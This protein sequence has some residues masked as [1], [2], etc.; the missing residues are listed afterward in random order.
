MRYPVLLCAAAAWLA[1]ADAPADASFKTHTE[2]AYVNTSGNTDASAFAAT[3]KGAKTFENFALRVDAFG[4]YAE[5]NNVE[6]KNQWG[7]ELNY[8]RTLTEHLAFNYLVGYKDDRFSG[9]DYQFYTGPGLLHHT[10]A[11]EAHTLNTQ[12][13]ILYARDR[14]ETGDVNEYA[15]LK[16][17]LDY[18]W[19]IQ[20]NLKL[21]EEAS[22]RTDLSDMK[23]YFLT[24]KTALQNKINSTF[25]MGVSYKVDYTNEPVDGKTTTDKTLMVSLIIDY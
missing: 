17:G 6:S 2:L 18:E 11:T 20:E 21:I 12:V 15:A 24:S 4:N 7:I 3:F 10:L 9:Y 5:D 16:A 1:A 23:N 19:R 14:V 13:N 8:D 25:S 22:I